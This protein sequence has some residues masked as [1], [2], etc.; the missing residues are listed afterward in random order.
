MTENFMCFPSPE[1][2]MGKISE[3]MTEYSGTIQRVQ[4][5]QRSTDETSESLRL[6][7][8]KPEKILTDTRNF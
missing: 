8:T 2:N 7:D 3:Y 6:D 5:R 1:D 4:K